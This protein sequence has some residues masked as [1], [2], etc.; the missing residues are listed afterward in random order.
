[1]DVSLKSLKYSRSV[2]LNLQ[3]IVILLSTKSFLLFF[4][5]GPPNTN[6]RGRRLS[7]PDV[8]SRDTDIP[9]KD[10]GAVMRNGDVR[11]RIVNGMVSTAVAK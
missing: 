8:L 2:E 7:F 9:K 11:R 6:H 5:G 3:D 4:S 1:M 10:L